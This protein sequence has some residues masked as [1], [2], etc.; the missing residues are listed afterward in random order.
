[1]LRKYQ[2][3]RASVDRP[4]M[5]GDVFVLSPVAWIFFATIA[6]Q[7]VFATL[8][9]NEWMQWFG[10]LMKV[11]VCCC[12]PLQSSYPIRPHQFSIIGV[13]LNRQLGRDLS[14]EFRSSASQVRTKNQAL[15]T[16]SFSYSD[17]SLLDG[18]PSP[19]RLFTP[20]HEIHIQA[21]GSWIMNPPFLHLPLLSAPLFSYSFVI[22]LSVWFG[23]PP[24]LDVHRDPSIKYYLYLSLLP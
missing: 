5:Q 12:V 4:Y 20:I 16:P 6:A 10:H 15:L 18:S 3:K 23:V 21:N 2:K 8:H 17:G 19:L 24:R 22:S 11:R 9:W 7:I 14:F 1:M 13:F